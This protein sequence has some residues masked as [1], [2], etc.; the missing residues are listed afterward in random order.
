AFEIN[1]Q[2]LDELREGHDRTNEVPPDELAAANLFYTSD[3]SDL[4]PADYYIVTV[5]TPV[6]QANRPDLSM[7]RAVSD[8]GKLALVHATGR[9]SSKDCGNFTSASFSSGLM[10]ATA[11]SA[12]LC[13]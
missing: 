6:N 5:P 11:V 7:L 9:I 1:R 10:C 2:R 8:T 4:D 3:P 13:T 12:V